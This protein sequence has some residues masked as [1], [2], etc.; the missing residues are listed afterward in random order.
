[1]IKYYTTLCC[2]F[3]TIAIAAQ[4]TSGQATYQSKTT[5]DM[6]FGGP[7]M[8]EQ[9]KEQIAEMMKK[10]LEK[11]YILDFTKEES[12]Y[13]EEEK[14]A[15]PGA[16]GG[17]M[18]MMG[19]FTAGSQYKNIK[20]DLYLQEQEF[21][22][23]QFLIADSLPKL[24][25]TL[26]NES[27]QIGQYVAFKATAIKKL[28]DTDFQSM[29]RRNRNSEVEKEESTTKK[30]STEF[31]IMEEVEIPN[32]IEIVAWYTPQIPIS[33][34]PGEFSGLPGLILEIQADRTSVLC[35]KIVL[36][37]KETIEIKKP[38]KGQKV[39]QEE[40]QKIVKDKIEEMQEM[41]GGRGRGMQIR[42][43]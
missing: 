26:V 11:T 23:K 40:Y 34:G 9:M 4:I 15:A 21:F 17:M 10:A 7:Q 19:N 5:V 30:D 25:W 42:M 41:Y 16:G 18:A 2:F 13:K 8:T 14:L 12:I 28:G 32:E 24:E 39:T 22:G 31:D 1:M 43:N 36:N 6:D 27:K 29:R 38:S 35:S 3:F 37:P 33:Q 20:E